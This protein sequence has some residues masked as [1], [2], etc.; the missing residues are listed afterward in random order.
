[1][2]NS[3]WFA[4]FCGNGRLI[5]DAGCLVFCTIFVV[6]LD[7]ILAAVKGSLAKHGGNIDIGVLA[8][9]PLRAGETDMAFRTILAIHSSDDDAILAVLAFYGNAV[10]TILARFTVMADDNGG[11]AFGVHGDFAVLAVFASHTRLALLADGQLV[12]ELDVVGRLAIFILRCDKQVPFGRIAIGTI[13]SIGSNR[14]CCFIT[15]FIVDCNDCMHTS[16]RC[17]LIDC[18]TNCLELVFGSRTAADIGRIG[19]IPI[20]VVKASDIVAGLAFLGNNRLAIFTD[21][22][23]HIERLVVEAL[24]DNRIFRLS[25]II[26]LIATDGQRTILFQVDIFIQSNLDGSTFDSGLDIAVTLLGGCIVRAIAA[27]LQ[28]I[29]ELLV[30]R[31]IHIITGKLQAIIHGSHFM[32]NDGFSITIFVGDGRLVLDAG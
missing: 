8:V 22:C 18:V 30:D 3:L 6:A 11:A 28:R 17:S 10:F 4:I 2:G 14:S 26:L 27:N 7:F 24:D 23:D 32:G 29:V 25:R 21:A 15:I 5:L 12:V 9:S 1:M 13:F 19:Y 16:C 20:L 31:R